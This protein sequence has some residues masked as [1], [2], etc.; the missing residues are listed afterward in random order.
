MV[1]PLRLLAEHDLTARE[2]FPD[3]ELLLDVQNLSVRYRP[4]G[5]GD[6][7]ALR[8]A[9]LQIAPGQIVGVLGESGSGKSTLAAS[10]LTL[11]PVNGT[12]DAGAVVL[13]GTNLLELEREELE[14]V[15]GVKVSL[16]FQEPGVAL[17]PMM[18]VGAQ[19]EEVLQAHGGKD[20]E[21]RRRAVRELLDLIFGGGGANLSF[22][23]TPVERWAAATDCDRTG[24]CM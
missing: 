2:A 17:H 6:V 7:F 9:N 19:I 13:Q 14:R 5:G 15:R 18:R 21:G 16:I 20:K 24:D 23:P 11:L 8:G 3:M 10:V 1:V 12:I 4:P 22:L